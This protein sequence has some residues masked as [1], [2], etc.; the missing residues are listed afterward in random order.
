M[1]NLNEAAKC[2]LLRSFEINLRALN[3][4]VQSKRCGSRPRGFDE[5]SSQIRAWSR[6]LH[7]QLEGLGVLVR[8]AVGLASSSIRQQRI[9]A[10]LAHAKR[11]S[12]SLDCA[13]VL[14]VAQ[15]ALRTNQ[16]ALRSLW[17]QIVRAVSCPA[18]APTRT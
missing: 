5:V 11:E 13:R 10:L 7:R 3:A 17:Q 14:E 18:R 1:V 8:K 16:S 12:H 15:T 2:L 4:I 6:N 9:A